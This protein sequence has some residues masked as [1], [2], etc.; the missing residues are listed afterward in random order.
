MKLKRHIQQFLKNNDNVILTDKGN[1]TVVL[2]RN[3]YIKKINEML[4]D[5]YIKVKKDP[6]KRIIGNLRKILTT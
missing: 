6:T 2:D 4:S 1:I 3:N 5:I